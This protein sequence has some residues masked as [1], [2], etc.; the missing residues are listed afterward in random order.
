[1]GQF[2]NQVVGREIDVRVRT[3]GVV[4]GEKLVLRILDKSRSVYT[5]GALGMPL[6]T[7]ARYGRMIRSPYGMVICAGPTGSGKTTTLY[8]ALTELDGDD[9]N[10]TT[11]ED[12]VEYVFPTINQIQIN[13][14]A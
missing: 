7:A 13:E 11:I 14:A 8:A 1:A 12:P 5:L 3:A 10:V 9:R 4:W 6:A 2:S